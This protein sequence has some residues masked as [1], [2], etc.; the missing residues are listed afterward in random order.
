MK[1]Y[2]INGKFVLLYFKIIQKKS[3]TFL[4]GMATIVTQQAQ[5]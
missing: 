4:S 3:R 2:V 1:F 5:K